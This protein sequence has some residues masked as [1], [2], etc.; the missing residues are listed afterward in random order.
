[1]DVRTDVCTDLPLLHKTS[2]PFRSPS[3]PLPKNQHLHILLI[4]HS[5][6]I[7][8]G[9]RP[10]FWVIHRFWIG[11]C[12]KKPLKQPRF[13]FNNNLV[14]FKL[15]S[16]TCSFVSLKFQD[17]ESINWA[18]TWFFLKWEHFPKTLKSQ[19]KL[20]AC[21]FVFIMISKLIKLQSWAWSQMKDIW[22]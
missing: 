19:G 4:G 16:I 20:L 1:M 21:I 13:L 11:V 8:G 22:I 7:Q 2:I 6:M 14:F 12:C 17:Y 3:E 18:N 10:L 5:Q 9:S 15:L